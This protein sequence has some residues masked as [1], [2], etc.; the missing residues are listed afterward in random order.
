[1]SASVQPS[2]GLKKTL[3]GTW[4]RRRSA[5]DPGEQKAARMRGEENWRKE[6]LDVHEVDSL[7]QNSI[8][9]SHATTGPAFSWLRFRNPFEAQ[10][11]YFG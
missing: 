6:V 7:G 9:K 4:L 1:M 2:F 11:N 8:W 3:T 5:A 10:R